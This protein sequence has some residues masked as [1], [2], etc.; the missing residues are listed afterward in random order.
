MTLLVLAIVVAAAALDLAPQGMLPCTSE[1]CAGL[2]GQGL[3]RRSLAGRSD[4]HH[5]GNPTFPAPCL[6]LVVEVVQLRG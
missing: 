2:V 6:E 4:E 1:P 3:F 5:V